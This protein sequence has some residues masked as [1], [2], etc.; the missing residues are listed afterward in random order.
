MSKEF[1]PQVYYL[2]RRKWFEQLNKYCEAAIAKKGKDPLAIFWKAFATGMN[3]NIND[4]LRLLDNF[5]SRRDMQYPVTLAKIFFHNKCQPID[6]ETVES[7]NADLS[8]AEEIT[9]H[10]FILV[11]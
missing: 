6:H 10:H 2:A 4:C 5:Q 8:I 11:Y 3:G 1:K 9:V 7:L